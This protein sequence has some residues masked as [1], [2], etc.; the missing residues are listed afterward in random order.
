MYKFSSEYS[1]SFLL[2]ILLSVHTL[3]ESLFV[4]QSLQ[5]SFGLILVTQFLQV[6]LGRGLVKVIFPVEYVEVDEGAVDV[7]AAH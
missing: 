4:D 3:E 7:K 5:F 2:F 6:S 1:A